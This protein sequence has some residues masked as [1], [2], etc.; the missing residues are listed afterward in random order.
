[1]S[2]FNLCVALKKYRIQFEI[3]KTS[4]PKITERTSRRNY[5][6]WAHDLRAALHANPVHSCIIGA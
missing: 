5:E 6:F 2:A 3:V 1:M 4:S